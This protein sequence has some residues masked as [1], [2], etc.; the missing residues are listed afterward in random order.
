[1][2]KDTEEPVNQQ[3]YDEKSIKVLGGLEAVRKRPAMYIGSTG[4]MGLHHLVY[5]VVDNSVDEALAGHCKNIDVIIHTDNSVTV[6][7][8][9]RGIPGKAPPGEEKADGRGRPDRAPR[10]WQVREQGL[11]GLRRPARRRRHGRQLPLGVAQ[12]RDKKGR[13]GIPAEVRARQAG[14]APDCRG[15][16]KEDRHDRLVQA[17]RRDIRGD[18]F[19][20]RHSLASA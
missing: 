20:L 12:H 15:Q 14:K 10:R 13:T 6:M 11:Q 4:P 18:R 16:D 7:D 9:G 1:M 3:S 17:R 19:Q 8:D 2:K 5:E